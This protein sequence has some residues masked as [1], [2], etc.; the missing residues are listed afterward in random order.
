M[1]APHP[2]I[3]V[4]GVIGAGK[5][6][7]AT[8]LAARY[9]A[10]LVLEEFADNSFLPQFY[11]EPERYAFPLELSFLAARYGQLKPLLGD[12]PGP[13]TPVVSDYIFG[14]S[15]LFA[16]VNL[17]EAE[18]SLFRTLYGIIDPQLRT[19]DVLL[20][21]QSPTERLQRNIAAR[22]RAYETAIPDSYLEKLAAVYA[23]ALPALP[24]PVLIIDAER[25]D[26]LAPNG[27]L[28]VVL[29]ELDGPQPAGTR[30]L[31]FD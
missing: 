18:Y 6:T 23:A 21:L 22:G 26:F 2:Y 19:P 1:T 27:H 9:G 11:A 31:T 4:E 8:L 13:G 14:K 30:F 10:H 5:T 12:G 15:D 25:A 7:L 16:R 24:C 20:Y 17:G 28:E 3:A 29:R